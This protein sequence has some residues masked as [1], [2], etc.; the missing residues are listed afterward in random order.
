M[1]ADKSV[2]LKTRTLKKI[3]SLP[4]QVTQA[5]A[6]CPTFAALTI[7]C[8]NFNNPLYELQVY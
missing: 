4:G 3:L 8:L 5:G 6:R 2:L 7:R 1:V